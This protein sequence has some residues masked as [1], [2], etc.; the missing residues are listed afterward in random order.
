MH[1]D[2]PIQ[3]ASQ[4]QTVRQEKADGQGLI[5]CWIH[6]EPA[7]KL[8]NVEGIPVRNVSA[9]ASYHR[10]YAHCV[11]QVVESGW[12]KDRIRER[13]RRRSA[14]QPS[15][16]DVGTQQFNNAQIAKVFPELAGQERA[17]SHR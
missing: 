4:L 3:E 6:K 5:P 1:Y 11:G 14:W 13:R 7:H 9:E 2:P 12:G 15:S 10:P 8:I 16:D 17:L